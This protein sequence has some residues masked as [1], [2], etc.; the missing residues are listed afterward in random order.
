M[1][2][3]VYP[4]VTDDAGSTIEPESTILDQISS[5]S[6][7][8]TFAVGRLPLMRAYDAEYADPTSSPRSV[9]PIH[10]IDPTDDVVRFTLTLASVEFEAG[11]LEA[12]E[13]TMCLIDLGANAFSADHGR[14]GRLSEDM[15]FRW[16]KGE[17]GGAS[18]PSPITGVFTLPRVAA[19]RSVRALVQ[20]THL[21]PAAGGV[22][23]KIYTRKNPKEVAKLLAKEEKRLEKPA[24]PGT[25]ARGVSPRGVFA[26]AT[27]NVMRRVLDADGD[28]AGAG[29]VRA[30]T[31]YRVKETYTEAQ[32]L[33]AASSTAHAMKNHKPV[34][35]AVTLE[36][37]PLGEGRVMEV[38]TDNA[39]ALR[40]FAPREPNDAP[41]N[42]WDETETETE[43]ETKTRTSTRATPHAWREGLTRDLYVYVD[44]V[45]FGRRRDARV[46]VQL[47]NDDLDIDGPGARAVV[48]S[49]GGVAG[50]R[51]GERDDARDDGTGLNADPN[52]DPNADP[53]EDADGSEGVDFDAVADS[54]P[55]ADAD[56]ADGSVAE[57]SRSASRD[58][59]ENEDEADDVS[60]D[61]VAGVG[62]RLRRASWT[63]LSTGKARGGAWNHEVRVRLP[64][65]LD[66][67]H[68]LVFTV[69]GREPESTTTG[70]G[71]VLATTPG[72]ETA[73]GHAV[74]PL[75]SAR[76][77]L[78]EELASARERDAEVH[79]PAV[80]ELL[81]KYLQSNVK[82]HMHYWEDR[83]PCVT[84]R[85]R[86]GSNAHTSDAKIGALYAATA[87]AA[88]AAARH[89]EEE[90]RFVVAASQSSRRGRAG[91]VAGSAGGASAAARAAL[92]SAARGLCAALREVHDAEASELLRHLPAVMHL[93]LSTAIDP[94]ESV[95]AAVDADAALVASAARAKAAAA[96]A[97]RVA[98]AAA[99][100]AA[101]ADAA[102]NESVAV[103]DAAAPPPTPFH[104]P[105]PA[106]GEKRRDGVVDENENDD[107]DDENEDEN[108]NADD[109]DEDGEAS[110][111]TS[112][113]GL[114]ASRST[115]RS[116]GSRVASPKT[117]D[118]VAASARG[119]SPSPATTPGGE[120]PAKI[121]GLREEAFAAVVRVAA[122]VRAIAP[123]AGE[124]EDD[125]ENETNAFSFSFSSSPP[126]AAY[127]DRVFDDARVAEAWRESTAL[128][129][130]LDPTRLDEASTSSEPAFPALAS[131][132]AASLRAT[133]GFGKKPPRGFAGA[134]EVRAASG[135]VLGL[136]ARSVALDA[137]R[138]FDEN[139]GEAE[140]EAE[141]EAD[142]GDGEGDGD[143]KIGT[144]NDRLAFRERPGGSSAPT[145][146]DP[147]FATVRRLADVVSAD[148]CDATSSGD[149]TRARLA[150]G[151]N[152][153]VA[154]LCSALMDV[155]GPPD[156]PSTPATASGSSDAPDATPKKTTAF[157]RT[158]A[159]PSRARG[160]GKRGAK[161][162]DEANAQTNA[163]SGS[164]A[165]ASSASSGPAAPFAALARDVAAAHLRR[166]IASG[167]STTTFAFY[168]AVARAPEF[169]STAAAATRGAGW[170]P[171]DLAAEDRDD[172]EDDSDDD[173]NANAINATANANAMGSMG[174]GSAMGG[175]GA[176]TVPGGDALTSAMASATMDGLL[177]SDR[178]RRAAAARALRGALSRHAWDARLQSR[179]ARAAVAATHATTL[180]RLLSRR[181]DVVSALDSES[182]RDVL[183]AALAI[184]RD[185]DQA[186]LWSWL[187]S[188]ARA[189]GSTGTTPTRPPRLVA[190]LFLLRDALEAFE[191]ADVVGS[192]PADAHRC[193]AVTLAVVELVASGR[194]RVG[195]SRRGGGGGGGENAKEKPRSTL[196]AVRGRRS[197]SAPVASYFARASKAEKRGGGAT[198]EDS[199]ASR[200]ARAA[201]RAASP[202][203]T[204]LEGSLG[205]L[206]AAMRA[207]Q[208][209]AA[210]RAISPLLRRV[211]WEDRQALL[212]PMLRPTGGGG[213]TADADA[214]SS[215]TLTSTSSS[216]KSRER[217][218]DS[219]PDPELDPDP[220]PFPPP[221][222]VAP[223][224]KP[225]PFLEKASTCL[226]RAAAS[227]VADIRVEASACLRALLEAA[228]DAAGAV[229]VLRPMLTY[230]LCAALY[231]PLGEAARRG[232]LAES[233]ASL[234][235]PVTSKGE[236]AAAA[237]DS[238][239]GDYGRGTTKPSPEGW[240]SAAGATVQAL[241]SAEARLRELARAATG[242]DAS[243]DVESVV[244]MECAVASALAWAPAAH[245]KALR[246]LSA[247]LEAGQHWVEAAEAAATAAGVTV[248]ALAAAY[249]AAE[250]PEATKRSVSSSS[251]KTST[252][253]CVWSDDDVRS[254]RDACASLG[255]D[256][257]RFPVSAAAAATSARCGVEEISEE[258]VLAHL[259]EAVRLFVK[260]GHLEAAV[261][262]AK[263]AL[264]A[265]ERRR[266]F[267]DLARAHAGVAGIYR[268]LH[269]L[270]PPG[271]A[272]AGTFGM[273]P[274]PPGPP[275]SPA[276]F[277]RVRLV[278]RAWGPDRENTTWVHREPRD[279]T[280]GDMLARLRGSLAEGLPEGTAPVPLPP[281]GDPGDD[282][283]LHIIAVEPVYDATPTPTSSS[284]SS[285]S[286][287][288]SGGG[289]GGGAFPTCAAFVYDV[290]FVPDD[291]PRAGTGPIAALR[292]TWRRRGTCR[293]DGRFPGLRARL[294]VVEE[295]FA[296]MSP[297][298]SAAEML[299][300]QS[301]AI[302]AAADAWEK[303]SKPTS[304]AV[305][306][307]V[308]A[309]AA[310]DDAANATAAAGALGALRRS[311]QGSLAAEVN[312]GVPAVCEAF[313]PRPDRARDPPHGIDV[314]V[315]EVGGSDPGAPGTEISEEHARGSDAPGSPP[316]S[317][318]PEPRDA[319][320]PA[321]S[322]ED[323]VA[324]E[325]ALESFL[326]TCARAVETHGNAARDA[327]AAGGSATAVEQT[328]AMFARRLAEIRRDVARATRDSAERSEYADGDGDGD[329]DGD[330]DGNDDTEE[331]T[332]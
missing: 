240:E 232:A 221:P 131:L 142:G 72:A 269:Q 28:G 303:L 329:A 179:E 183:A 241:E 312:G 229:T 123:G 207:R 228:L 121:P 227:P 188:R 49:E 187:S 147:R 37:V 129:V 192:N 118:S 299:R 1:L 251:S 56:P 98:K 304:S 184:A 152:L 138:R 225:Y 130:H 224:E 289:V 151:L 89:A 168:G 154:R 278:G 3:Q 239:S 135:F 97:E 201:A 282:A 24:A 6:D 176:E 69:Y 13:G 112:V 163:E 208:S 91:N 321:A 195:E 262:A 215:S 144:S 205:I 141:T 22:D 310:L 71:G 253:S 245:C 261:R 318:E 206:L 162:T 193:A 320:S 247:R 287:S 32:L 11:A 52:D 95:A 65:R 87:A 10:P 171:E 265:W 167:D 76:E 57:G 296:E 110:P 235:V 281:S 100:A 185:A 47:R 58:E 120:R 50:G 109:D 272:G 84:L 149:A 248:Q 199:A 198:E 4:P 145:R 209:V 244:D 270:P 53:N 252:S 16:K 46:R 327:A 292:A 153:G 298:A 99:A 146:D 290:P 43:T 196:S 181:H 61:G 35:A 191:H 276:T 122:R 93:T 85:L 237:E 90:T 286:K 219:T 293:V 14:R 88:E 319:T 128:P 200:A 216:K 186:S 48:V 104:T 325:D 15:H 268:S 66:P 44:A 113:S 5:T 148:V 20:L 134:E 139:E 264:P 316:A 150:R 105:G 256:G 55:D 173:A 306:G 132:Y 218:R 119:A 160:A 111:S 19:R 214:A 294:V 155:E 38:T 165:S 277:Y 283:C 236:S 54:D 161:A 271:A 189:P 42:W 267:G 117:P 284:S 324:L 273:L 9:R 323:R 157:G 81:P 230:A 280:L 309:G 116:I 39:P 249:A 266:A 330:G 302:A 77:T 275:P 166:L 82:A 158:T 36:V 233:L 203:T 238:D 7:A 220:E 94:P 326:E 102:V 243:P 114:S 223:G 254:L 59:D 177:S 332:A 17:V 222:A 246:S 80:K 133:S 96:R 31:M 307:G 18:G 322:A 180:R 92:R 115:T 62:T 204:F 140:A 226:L 126:L 143:K 258:K 101:V 125:G 178:E 257:L 313:F 70:W 234:R 295:T 64:A 274:P 60:G 78:A 197:D 301:R 285:A 202:E 211:L 75:A 297:A 194:A 40:S 41:R 51:V 21:V 231:A 26:W 103:A 67:G 331:G 170:H 263:V 25:F 30:E 315:A 328:Q 45:S 279:R 74:L 34:R 127:V 137:R 190:F 106:T 33:E 250:T 8:E 12:V 108:E 169:V 156:A 83:K 27:L 172:A 291:A 2:P 255:D 63:H 164:G 305:V 136:I 288:S 300:A 107:A 260:G 175:A 217:A 308:G 124:E 73:L 317:N 79:L 213:A 311:L 259:A 159:S 174:S 68:H 182:R 86:L 29:S 314:D 212:A 242:P 23:P 210:W